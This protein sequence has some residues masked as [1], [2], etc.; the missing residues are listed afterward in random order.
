MVGL[1]LLLPPLDAISAR[2]RAC[3]LA[4]SSS[5]SPPIPSFLDFS[6][7]LRRRRLLLPL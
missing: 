4:P 7:Q 1:G 6:D 5:S 2:A 3:G